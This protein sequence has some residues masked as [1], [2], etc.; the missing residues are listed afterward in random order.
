MGRLAMA[1]LGLLV[2]SSLYLVR[3]SYE[4]RRL[5]HQLDKAQEESRRLQAE[6]ERLKAQS[7]A[8]ATPLR[9]ERV[10]RESLDM[11]MATPAMMQYVAPPP[12]P[13]VAGASR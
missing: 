4:E 3:V 7:Q 1:L 5:F 13:S 8:Q 2:L 12:T 6:F 11:R 10:A 9:V